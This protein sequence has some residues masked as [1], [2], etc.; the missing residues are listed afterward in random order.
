MYYS[1]DYNLIGYGLIII[2]FL[3]TL[4]ADIYLQTTYSKMKKTQN[5]KKLIVL[6]KCDLADEKSLV[7]F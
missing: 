1:F 5:K 2:G 4:V 7:K 6:N 3:I